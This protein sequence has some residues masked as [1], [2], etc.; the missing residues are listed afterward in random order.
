MIRFILLFIFITTVSFAQDAD[1]YWNDCGIT[2]QQL[3]S[4]MG[5]PDDTEYQDSL[6]AYWFAYDFGESAVIYI[7]NRGFV[8]AALYMKNDTNYVNVRKTFLEMKQVANVS[9]FSLF[10][11][12]DRHFKA[13]RRNI[14]LTG[15]ITYSN[16]EYI[17]IIQANNANKSNH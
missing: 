15:N 10:N 5:A 14:K 8:S 3:F 1:Y 12:G 16:K 6:K 2:L 17:L 13:R 7:V 4:K 11:V 9:G